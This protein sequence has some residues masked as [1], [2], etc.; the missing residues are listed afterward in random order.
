MH[1]VVTGGSSGIGLEVAKV[2]ARRGASVSLI[3]RNMDRLEAARNEIERTLKD[4]GKVFVVGADVASGAELSAA[5]QACEAALGPCDILV[6]S[7][8]VVEPGW[9]H[10]QQADVFQAQWQ[11][12]VTGVVN[13]VRAVYAGMRRRGEGRIMIVCS[14]A[15]FIG[16]PA[17]TAYCASKS[18]LVGFTDALRLE[19]MPVGVAVGICFPPD[20]DTPQLTRELHNRP[21]EAEM[22]MGRIKPRRAAEIA[23]KIISG[24]DRR[25]ARVY[26][27]ASITA[28]GLFG[29]LA[30]PFI[31]IWYRLRIRK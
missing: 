21:K 9:F 7:A 23:E 30:R 12:N 11:T 1:V 4:S 20:T 25:S 31:E 16:I 3:A 15:A 26:F 19:A 10:E 28:L 13:A 29:P 6:A 5:I 22:L 24:I 27:T 8:G 14:A 18:A 2:Y 17:Y